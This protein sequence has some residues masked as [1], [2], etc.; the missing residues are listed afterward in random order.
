M[1]EIRGAII[2]QAKESGMETKDYR[3]NEIK[4]AV[5]GYGAAS[6]DQVMSA[7][8]LILGTKKRDITDDEYDAIAIGITYLSD[9]RH[10]MN[11]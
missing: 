10:T 8:D 6:K 4:L 3:P 2:A 11:T 1:S 9:N 5:T 7:V